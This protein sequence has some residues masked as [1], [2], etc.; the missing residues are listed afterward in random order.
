MEERRRAEREPRPLASCL[1]SAVVDARPGG[2]ES[3]PG[4]GRVLLPPGGCFTL[5][6]GA[7]LHG[8]AGPCGRSSGRAGRPPTGPGP[9]RASRAETRSVPVCVAAAADTAGCPAPGLQGG[10]RPVLRATSLSVKEWCS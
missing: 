9:R 10:G 4:E 1:L 6:S 3:S 7:R 5:T 2:P 8:A